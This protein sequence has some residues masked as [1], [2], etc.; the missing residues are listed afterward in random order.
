[1]SHEY[2]TAFAHR[3]LGPM[4]RLTIVEGY[5]FDLTYQE[6]QILSRALAAVKNKTSS[7]ADVYM[8]PIASDGDFFAKV[9]PDGILFEAPTPPINLTWLQVGEMAEALA[10]ASAPKEGA[11]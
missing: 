6:A 2:V 11:S 1:M 9:L 8:S 5:R 7:V 3:G 10:A 4:I